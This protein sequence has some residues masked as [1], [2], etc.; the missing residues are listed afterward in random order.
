MTLR[1]LYNGNCPICAREISLYR[2]LAE[3][4]AAMLRFED[5]NSVDLGD[6]NLT[7]DQARRRLHVIDGDVRLHGLAAFRALW[8][9]LPGWRWLARAAAMPVLG[10]LLALACD[11]VAAPLLYRL[12][13]WREGRAAS[14]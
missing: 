2:R 1:I 3:R 14:G 8:S 7:P 10:G 5:L 6:W 11:R 4:H 9:R 13:L 12:T